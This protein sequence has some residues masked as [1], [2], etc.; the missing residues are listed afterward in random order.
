MTFGSPFWR[1]LKV[2]RIVDFRRVICIFIPEASARNTFAH[3]GGVGDFSWLQNRKYPFIRK[4]I[5]YFH[6][7]LVTGHWSREQTV[8]G[9][10]KESEK[11]K[12]KPDQQSPKKIGN[13]PAKLRLTLL[14][15]SSRSSFQD[16]K[17][18]IIAKVL[19][20]S[21]RNSSSMWSVFFCFCVTGICR[22][23]IITVSFF[24]CFQ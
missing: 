19:K 23:A 4:K 17:K 12:S 15:T 24:P 2:L 8:Q 18:K 1:H 20:I 16:N 3:R 5:K 10:N 21:K 13:W 7:S 22:S 11:S 9:E 6:W 14:P